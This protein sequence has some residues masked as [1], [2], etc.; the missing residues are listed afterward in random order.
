ML[1]HIVSGCSSQVRV[2]FQKFALFDAVIRR[3]RDASQ[4]L[5]CV[6]YS[7]KAPDNHKGWVTMIIHLH[8]HGSLAQDSSILFTSALASSHVSLFFFAHSI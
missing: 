2:E 8:A 6:R 7:I 5:G 3:F 4:R 1:V